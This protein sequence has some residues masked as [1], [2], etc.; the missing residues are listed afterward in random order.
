MYDIERYRTTGALITCIEEL[1]E[2]ESELNR[3]LKNKEGIPSKFHDYLEILN[4]LRIVIRKTL[5]FA[6]KIDMHKSSIP[7]FYEHKGRVVTRNVSEFILELNSREDYN[8]N[9]QNIFK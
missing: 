4:E 2:R 6:I 3:Y 5:D 1:L 9:Y 7:Y 8:P